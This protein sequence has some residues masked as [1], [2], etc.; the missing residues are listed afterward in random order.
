[1]IS[2]I[3]P[4]FF[5]KM[6]ITCYFVSQCFCLELNFSLVLL[7]LK[8]L[9]CT[10]FFA[11]FGSNLMLPLHN[12]IL[13]LHTCDIFLHW[14]NMTSLLVWQQ[15]PRKDQQLFIRTM[16]QPLDA[17]LANLHCKYLWCVLIVSKRNATFSRWRQ[18]R[19]NVCHPTDVYSSR[20]NYWTI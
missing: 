16:S 10:H 12:N 3:F 17:L 11:I 5:I 1:M 9:Y 14:N 2:C 6:R 4:C 18:S 19:C 7:I 8:S 13:P 20:L 15:S